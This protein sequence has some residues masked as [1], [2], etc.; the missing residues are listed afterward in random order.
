MNADPDTTAPRAW[1][2]TPRRRILVLVALALV[3]GVVLTALL[4][5]GPSW[6]AY[7][8]AGTGLV[9]ELPVSPEG[10]RAGTAAEPV[11]L[12]QARSADLAVLASGG[13]VPAG[14]APS[15]AFLA[16]QAMA[17]VQI[18]PGFTD[19]EYQLGEGRIDGTPCLRVGG[20]FRRDGVPCR[21]S[22]VFIVT[23]ETHGHL[24]CFW[25]TAEGARLARRVLASVRPSSS[26]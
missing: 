13:A 24:L 12:F 17:Q 5:R 21:L 6:T 19:L 14:A 23:A 11:P 16:R 1:L 4:W 18:S 25:Q 26:R 10:S 15:A 3:L 2:S 7:E 9:V 20:T 22:G 8:L